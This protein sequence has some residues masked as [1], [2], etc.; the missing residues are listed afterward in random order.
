M[1]SAVLDDGAATGIA[2][3]SSVRHSLIANGSGLIMQESQEKKPDPDFV[4][5]VL[6]QLSP[7]R[8]AGADRRAYLSSPLLLSVPNPVEFI[9][10]FARPGWF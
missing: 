10:M 9:S 3:A 7:I 8:S 1:K 5:L 2:S 6:L 4:T